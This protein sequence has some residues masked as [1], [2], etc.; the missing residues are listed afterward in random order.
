MMPRL[1]T[2]DKVAL[3]IAI[4]LIAGGFLALAYPQDLFMGR[5]TNYPKEPPGDAS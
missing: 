2:T 1:E 5:A 3:A 4:I